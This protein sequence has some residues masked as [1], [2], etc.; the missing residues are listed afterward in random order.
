MN[1]KKKLFGAL[2]VF[3]ALVALPIS[4]SAAF[5]ADLLNNPTYSLQQNGIRYAEQSLNEG[6][7]QKLFYGEYNT[8][9]A[10]AE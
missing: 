2:A 8:A 4:V 7:V 5:S 9:S 6:G 10:D 1:T 3:M